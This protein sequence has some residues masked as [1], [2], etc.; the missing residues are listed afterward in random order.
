[1][2]HV[3]K[4]NFTTNNIDTISNGD[5]K[6]H[7]TEIMKVEKQITTVCK[8]IDTDTLEGYLDIEIRF[9]TIIG[10]APKQFKASKK[11]CVEFMALI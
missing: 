1:M 7:R 5:A 8:D 4:K 9:R 3:S 6:S 2:A 11:V 10:C